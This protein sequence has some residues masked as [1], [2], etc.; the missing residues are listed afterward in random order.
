MCDYYDCENEAGFNAQSLYLSLQTKQSLELSFTEKNTYSYFLSFFSWFVSRIRVPLK[1]FSFLSVHSITVFQFLTC[2][3]LYV[4][5]LPG[6]SWGAAP[7]SPQ[8]A[9]SQGMGSEH[10]CQ[11]ADQ[12]RDKDN[13]LSML[14]LVS[15]QDIL[16]LQ[17]GMTLGSGPVSITVLLFYLH[18]AS[19][20]YSCLLFLHN[21]T[22]ICGGR[23]NHCCL[24]SALLASHKLL[25]VGSS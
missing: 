23:L 10:F 14:A 3:W 25:S 9:G 1:P 4:P 12:L 18:T 21:L 2:P 5:F 19:F 16:V 22:F 6:P 8:R 13:S 11:L 17:T 20:C 7:L 15:S 24:F